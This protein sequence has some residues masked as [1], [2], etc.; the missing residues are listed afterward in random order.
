M[1]IAL[2]TTC[3]LSRCASPTTLSCASMSIRHS[4]SPGRLRSRRRRPSLLR[5][6]A[7]DEE[8]EPGRTQTATASSSSSAA[9][10]DADRAHMRSALAFAARA[11]AS[12]FP[13]PAVGCVVVGGADGDSV[14]GVGW[15]PRAGWPHAEVYALADVTGMLPTAARSSEQGAITPGD[16]ELLA[17]YLVQGGKLFEN[18]APGATAYVTLEPCSHT[19]KRTPPCT[20]ALEAAGAEPGVPARAC[21]RLEMVAFPRHEL[22]ASAPLS[23]HPRC[24]SCGPRYGRS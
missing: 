10:S 20:K 24:I 22:T 16:D 1:M 8:E 4:H 18:A 15:H 21:A 19:G 14:L 6:H 9:L 17:T 13:N 7:D 2:A 11:G 23:A 3:A 12:T 5:A